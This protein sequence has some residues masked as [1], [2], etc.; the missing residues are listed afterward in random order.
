M[1]ELMKRVISYAVPLFL[2]VIVVHQCQQNAEIKNLARANTNALTD[3]IRYYTNRLG[4]QTA[5]I[6]TLEL[7]KRQFESLIIEKDKELSKLVK[8]FASVT[9]V[10]QAQSEITIDTVAVKFDEKIPVG[11]SLRHFARSGTI[12][13][14]WYDVGY[15]ITA[16]SLVIS[17]FSTWTKTT[18]ITGTKRKWFLGKETLVTE[19]TY[20]NP[21]IRVNDIKAAEVTVPRPWYQKWYVWLA[22]GL[23]GGLVIK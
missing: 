10:T 6:R 12:K 4:S 5:T 21:Y 2:L 19:I 16:D 11:D 20:D 1:G 22:A 17:P 13:N 23:V 8:E 9:S 7:D 15:K 18:L 14:K 3:S